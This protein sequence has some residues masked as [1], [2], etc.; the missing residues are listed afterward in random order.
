MRSPEGDHAAD[1]LA[2][3][4]ASEIKAQSR[5]LRSQLEQRLCD[6]IDEKDPLTSKIPRPTAATWPDLETPSG[7]IWRV[8]AFQTSWREQCNAKRRPPCE[9]ENENRDDVGA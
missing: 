6:R 1:G 3:V 2:K 9:V 8:S 7:G 4:S 5:I